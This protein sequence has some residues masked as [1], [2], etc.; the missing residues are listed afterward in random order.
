MKE[1]FRKMFWSEVLASIFWG[2]FILGFVFIF[3]V[4]AAILSA[5]LI[6]ILNTRKGL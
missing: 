6:I 1:D 3:G 5:L 2:A 4:D